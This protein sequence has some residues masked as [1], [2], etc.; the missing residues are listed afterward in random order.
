MRIVN[1]SKL[2]IS[3]GVSI[4][5]GFVSSVAIERFFLVMMPKPYSNCDIPNSYATTGYSDLYTLIFESSYKYTQQLCVNLCFQ[6]EV[7]TQCQCNTYDYPF[8]EGAACQNDSTQCVANVT[9]TFLAT[10]YLSENC[11]PM[12][13]LQCNRTGFSPQVSLTQLNGDSFVDAIQRNANL[14]KDFVTK[15]VDVESARLSVAQVNVFYTT[16]SYLRAD[17]SPACDKVCV[18]ANVGG[19]IGLFMGVSVLSL[20]EVVETLIEIFF[21]YTQNKKHKGIQSSAN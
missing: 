15:D 12:C 7:L 8:F 6:K 20:G 9:E 1:S 13:P 2:S 19:S 11:M 4:P 3:D 5:P 14:R 17:E 10:D 16:M 18:L 21:V